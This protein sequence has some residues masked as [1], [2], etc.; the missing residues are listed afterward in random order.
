MT[1]AAIAQ[2]GERQT[3]DLKVPGSIPGLGTMLMWWDPEVALSLRAH[4]QPTGRASPGEVLLFLRRLSVPASG[5]GW[6]R[7]RAD[8][9]TDV[10]SRWG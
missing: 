2:L 3:E 1:S 5:A 9:A 4:Q 6:G 10:L 7:G 8:N